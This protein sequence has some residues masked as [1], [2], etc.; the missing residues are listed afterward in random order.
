MEDTPLAVEVED[1]P[2]A[3]EAVG[4]EDEREEWGVA[5][6]QPP[7]AGPLCLE[8]GMA[9]GDPR[10]RRGRAAAAP[11]GWCLRRM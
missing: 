11:E 3:V 9:A 1:T 7:R 4:A 6:D 8:E 2:L 10:S 5:V